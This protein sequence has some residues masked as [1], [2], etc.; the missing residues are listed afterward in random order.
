M[1]ISVLVLSQILSIL[2]AR[3]ELIPVQVDLRHISIEDI[4]SNN[5]DHVSKTI[6]GQIKSKVEI[7]TVI[8]VNGNWESMS[9][10]DLELSSYLWLTR[11]GLSA[12]F[13]KRKE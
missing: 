6:S 1:K 7:E 12:E 3:I 2:P 8:Y 11:S 10:N 13:E 9:L 5:V 4:R